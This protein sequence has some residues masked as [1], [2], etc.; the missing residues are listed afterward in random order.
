MIVNHWQS[1]LADADIRTREQLMT[2]QPTGLVTI[3]VVVV[4]ATLAASCGREAAR[5]HTHRV[6]GGEVTECR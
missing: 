1:T 5:C 6:T 3:G 2:S 4:L